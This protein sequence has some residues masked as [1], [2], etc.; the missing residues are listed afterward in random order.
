MAHKVLSDREPKV[1]PN[2]NGAIRPFW[3]P[4][5]REIA[6]FVNQGDQRG[7]WR[8][9]ISGAQP[10][11]LA[12]GTES[13]GGSWNGA[14]TLLLALDPH[15]GL[16]AMTA[17][18]NCCTLSRGITNEPLLSRTPLARSRRTLTRTFAPSG[19]TSPRTRNPTRSAFAMLSTGSALPRT[20]R[21]TDL[22]EA[23]WTELRGLVLRAEADAG[24]AAG[25]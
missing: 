1:I 14:N 25:G 18:A 24:T 7:L 10:E 19:L 16:Q 13:R 9:N 12:P 21:P 4:D 15:H 11:F 2:T 6:Y 3:S 8:V 22:A 17:S 5:S 23:R 20:S